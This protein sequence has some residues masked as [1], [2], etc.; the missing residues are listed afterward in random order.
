MEMLME[1]T[2]D[3]QE[4]GPVSRERA[5]REGLL[6]GVVHLWIVSWKDRE[7]RIWYQQ[8]AHSKKDFPDFFDIAVGGHIDA[9]EPKKEAILRE[10]RE[11]LGLFLQ[12]EKLRYLG[13]FRD[14]FRQGSFFDREAAY[15]Y[16]YEDP[17][18]AFHPG[19]EVSRMVWLPLE[20]AARRE[21]EGTDAV[22]AYNEDGT[23]FTIRGDEWC[24]H[25]GEFKELVLPVLEKE[26]K[27]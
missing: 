18:P 7:P 12:S 6:H 5:H 9:G 15:V 13:T 8:R 16:L 27:R 3:L 2:E 21:T 25:P 4:K 19:E 11:E 17:E 24:K 10:T 22:T 1:L 23:A 20:T 26:W 14:D